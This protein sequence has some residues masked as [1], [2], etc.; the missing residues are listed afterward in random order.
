M[1]SKFGLTYYTRDNCAIDIIGRFYLALFSTVNETH[2]GHLQ[3]IASVS[4]LVL[5]AMCTVDI[6][7]QT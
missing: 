5:S 6:L 4:S 2:C 1:A 7:F 3:H